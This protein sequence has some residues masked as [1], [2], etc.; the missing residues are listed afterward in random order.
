MAPRKPERLSAL[1]LTE[2]LQLAHAA[3][4]LH[5]LGVLAAMTAPVT[6]E[7]VA[8]RYRL[9]AC[10]LRGTLD[11][12]AARTALVQKDGDR[13]VA[14]EGYDQSARFLLD[15][16]ALAYGA[17]AVRLAE[18]L[19]HPSRARNAAQSTSLAR[20]F[21]PQV[22]A[23]PAIIRQL[24]FHHVLDL[25]CGA[26]G[27]L[28]ALAQ[29]DPEFTGWGVERDPAMCRVARKNLR[30]ARV[31]DRITLFEGDATRPNILPL[32][33]RREVQ[34]VVASQLANALTPAATVAWL[35]RLRKAFPS[36]PLL[37]ADYYGRLGTSDG[38]L[39]RE[40]WLHDYAQV[41][42]G[43]PVPPRDRDAWQSLYTAAGCRLVHVMEDPRTTL[44]VHVVVLGE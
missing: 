8:E 38:R 12:L 9:D 34:T 32:D 35:R 7:E 37:L 44:F 26:S 27:L 25:G 22:G 28:L 5:D 10:M 4:A 33:V 21:K 39:H 36:R 15:V 13:F 42:S 20:A 24:G 3:A 6:A 41:L 40:T 17:N 23:L 29:D 19:R 1:D 30:A 31:T 2:G 11:Y 14:A 16:Y 18:L 43:Q